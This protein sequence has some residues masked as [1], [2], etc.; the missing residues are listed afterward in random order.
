VKRGVLILH[1]AAVKKP[2]RWNT[3]S[4]SLTSRAKRHV[5]WDEGK[6]AW[7]S[8]SP[9]VLLFR[10]QTGSAPNFNQLTSSPRRMSPRDLAA[11]QRGRLADKQGAG[12]KRLPA[13]AASWRRGQIALRLSISISVDQLLVERV[14][15][16]TL[17]RKA[18]RSCQFN[19]D[20]SFREAARPDALIGPLA[21]WVQ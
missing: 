16:S 4:L 8:P 21:R 12:I 9:A 10:R 20:S 17:T 14:A 15:A 1:F 3:I 5:W 2:Q 7:H 11:G 13:P 6:A 19:F 18:N